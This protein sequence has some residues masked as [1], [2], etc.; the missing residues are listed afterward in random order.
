MIDARLSVFGKLLKLSGR[1]DIVMSQVSLN[2]SNS[3][4]AW[5]TGPKVVAAGTACACL[6]A[7]CRDW[8]VGGPRV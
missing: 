6:P 5:G 1:M 8:T 4:G 2:T 3:R 7:C